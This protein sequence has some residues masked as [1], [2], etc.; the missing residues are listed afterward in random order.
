[1]ARLARVGAVL[2]AV[3]VPGDALAYGVSE[4]RVVVPFQ[5]APGQR[6]PVV[7]VDLTPDTRVGVGIDSKP[8]VHLGEVRTDRHGH[9]TRWFVLPRSAPTGYHRLVA[10]GTDGSAAD[11]WLL[12]GEGTPAAPSASEEA[13]WWQDPTLLLLVLLVGG[14]A[15][16]AVLGLRSRRTKASAG[17]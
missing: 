3:L 11:T 15:A 16:L 10:A 14:A 4:P 12:V 17:A 2:V 7:V 13:P 5:V 1:M 8:I 6:F 9:V